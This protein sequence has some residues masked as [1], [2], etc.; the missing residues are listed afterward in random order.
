MAI[1][2]GA[3]KIQVEVDNNGVAAQL[4]DKDKNLSATGP[5]IQDIKVLVQSLQGKATWIRRQGNKVAHSLA[6]FGC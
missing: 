4:N 2:T 1:Q 5:I 6:R 3:T